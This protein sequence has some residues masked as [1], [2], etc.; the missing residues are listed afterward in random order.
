MYIREVNLQ[1]TRSCRQTQ[2]AKNG[3]PLRKSILEDAYKRMFENIDTSGFKEGMDIK[4]VSEI[5]IWVAQGFGNRELEKLKHDSGYKSNYYLNAVA[6]FDE[7]IEL[8]KSA[9]Y[10]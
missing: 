10:K 6:E 7:Y 3:Y 4:Q 5:I 9:F 2:K 1:E 8:M